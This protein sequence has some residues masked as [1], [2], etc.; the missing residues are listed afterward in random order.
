MTLA[1][2]WTYRKEIALGLLA[3]LLVSGALYIRHALAERATLQQ[4]NRQLQQQVEQAV[5]VQRMMIAIN[6]ARETVR[7]RSIRN[8]TVIDTEPA[9]VFHDA[10][11]LVLVPDGLLQAVYSSAAPRGTAPGHAPGA[12]VPT[13]GQPGD[14]LPR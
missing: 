1:A 4:Q 3:L 14:L 9:P 7:R 2:L 6:D 10:A 5:A 8:V 13:A 11:P 12:H